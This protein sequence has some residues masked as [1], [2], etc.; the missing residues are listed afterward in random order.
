MSSTLWTWLSAGNLKIGFEIWLDPLS[1]F[2]MLVVSG[3]RLPDPRLRDRLHEGRRRGAA[4]PRVQGAVRLLDAPARHGGQP[5]A[6][7]RGLGDGRARVVPADQL[8]APAGERGRGREEGV[9][10]QRVRRRDVRAG[11]VSDRPAGGYARLRHRLLAGAARDRP[12]Q[13]RCRADRAR[14]AGRRGREVRSGA[15][16]HVAARCHGGPDSGLGPDPRRDDGDGG[17]LPDRPHERVLRAG[18][19]RPAHGRRARRGDDRPGRPDRARPDRHQAR[20][21]LLDDEPD[22]LHV[23]RRRPRRVRPR[24]VPSDDARLLQGAALPRRRHRHSRAHRRAGHPQDGRDRAGAARGRIA[25]SSS[26]RSRS[27][28][29]RRSRGS[30]RRTRFSRA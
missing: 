9:H 27:L 11:P 6:P 2:M 1:V 24:H 5:A 30:S 22:R 7:A 19:D 8:L 13:H 10:R 14:P 23:R 29:S 15:L 4:L 21:R 18:A 12:G 26:A 16:A 3:R 20:D 28:R 25:T 17:R